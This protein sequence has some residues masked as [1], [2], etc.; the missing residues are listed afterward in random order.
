[1]LQSEKCSLSL[2][3]EKETWTI[4][5]RSLNKTCSSYEHCSNLES[6]LKEMIL[7]PTDTKHDLT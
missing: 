1:M 6:Y 2:P 3:W 4:G 7:V 5:D